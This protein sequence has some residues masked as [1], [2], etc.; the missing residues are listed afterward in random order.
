MMKTSMQDRNRTSL[1]DQQVTASRHRQH[2]QRDPDVACRRVRDR[3]GGP[4]GP[5]RQCR[6]SA[7]G[8]G[9][10]RLARSSPVTAVS[11]GGSVVSAYARYGRGQHDS[12]RIGQ[13]D[14]LGQARNRRPALPPGQGEAEHE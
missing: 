5:A 12:D 11:L 4:H 2:Q 9:T 3:A 8:R 6:T 7:A 14:E 1:L 13:A 10:T